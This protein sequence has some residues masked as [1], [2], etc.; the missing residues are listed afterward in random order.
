[1][2]VYFQIQNCDL[3]FSLNSVSTKVNLNQLIAIKILH[4]VKFNQTIQENDHSFEVKA[5]KWFLFFYLL[6]N[7]RYVSR[8]EG[9]IGC[10]LNVL[11]KTQIVSLIDRMKIVVNVYRSRIV[12]TFSLMRVE[13]VSK[14]FQ[15]TIVNV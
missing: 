4:E 10:K 14:R 11:D 8:A 13:I 1:M 7:Q 12:N 15:S 3:H 9:Y 2:I 6:I 5:L